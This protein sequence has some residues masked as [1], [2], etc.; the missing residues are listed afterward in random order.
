MPEIRVWGRWKRQDWNEYWRLGRILLASAELEYVLDE[1]GVG[2]I[3][4]CPWLDHPPRVSNFGREIEVFAEGA[5]DA[6]EKICEA[7]KA[8]TDLGAIPSPVSTRTEFRERVE[9]HL[10]HQRQ[11]FPPWDEKL[12]CL[13][14]SVD[15]DQG[16]GSKLKAARP[17][18][19][20]MVDHYV[21][22]MYNDRR[23]VAAMMLEPTAKG[24]ALLDELVARFDYWRQGTGFHGRPP[25]D[26]ILEYQSV[27]AR[28]GV[29]CNTSFHDGL[30]E[31]WYPI[32]IEEDSDRLRARDL[33]ATPLP[34]ELHHLLLDED[35]K[36]AGRYATYFYF[37]ALTDN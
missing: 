33:I 12:P 2:G 23:Y 22:G 25:L 21:D 30:S 31:G 3:D 36:P 13:I 19:W 6:Q 35:G 32:D 34:N 18:D 15:F 11:N 29:D 16:N 1:L 7:V 24:Q 8:L 28:Y 4:V 37:A 26:A 10:L 5:P 14:L 17:Q 20:R 27:L 9:R